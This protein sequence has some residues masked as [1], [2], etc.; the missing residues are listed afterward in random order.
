MLSD[1]K[2]YQA[3]LIYNKI[4][5][6]EKLQIK[7]LYFKKYFNETSEPYSVNIWNQKLVSHLV[8]KVEIKL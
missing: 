3:I 5:Q 6:F 1:T 2:L 7:I 8:S 4:L